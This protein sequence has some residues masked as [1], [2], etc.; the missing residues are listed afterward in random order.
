LV[1][2]AFLGWLALPLGGRWLDAGCGTGALSQAILELAAPAHVTGI[3]ASA[4]YVDYARAHVRDPRVQFRTGDA[5]A[6]PEPDG[7]HDAAVSGLM[8]N[9]VPDAARAVAELA[10]VTRGRGTVAVYVWDYAGE[11]QVMRHFWDAAV[12]QNPA[13][14][15]RDEGVRF[16]L[17][18]PGPLAALFQGAG[19]GGVEVRAIDVPTVISDFD[20]YWSPFLG[21]QGP[22]PGYAMALSQEQRAALRERIRAA[23]PSQPDGSIHLIARAWAVRGVV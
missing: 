16:P 3:D 23:L 18:Q 10:R 5:Q 17:C 4:G 2:R 13:A 6:L 12:A 19:L 9:F 8:L 15:E 11:M 21:G 22:A 7:G 14:R 1:A 20:D